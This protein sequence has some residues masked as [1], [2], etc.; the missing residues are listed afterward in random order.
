MEPVA[1]CSMVIWTCVTCVATWFQKNLTEDQL[2]ERA[3]VSSDLIDMVDS[4]LDILNRIITG[5]EMWCYLYD[6]QTKWQSLYW[7]CPTLPKKQTSCAHR[8]KSKVMLEVFFKQCIPLG[9]T[10]NKTMYRNI[11]C[12]L[13]DTIHWKHLELSHAGNWVLRHNS[14]PTHR[15]DLIYEYL[16]KHDITMLSQPPYS[17]NLAHADYYLY[18]RLK[19]ILN[20]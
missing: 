10:V 11:L 9:H 14:L 5:N 20:P 1:N 15:S 8:S 19:E 12:C 17:S 4:G 2:N 3:G 16:S 6:P 7:K 18:L 13:R